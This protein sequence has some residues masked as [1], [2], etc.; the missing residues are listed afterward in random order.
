MH[1]ARKGAQRIRKNILRGTGMHVIGREAFF[2]K[3]RPV[4]ALFAR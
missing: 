1:Q 2:D 4:G 3:E